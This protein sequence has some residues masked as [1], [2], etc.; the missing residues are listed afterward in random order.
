MENAKYFMEERYGKPETHSAD[1][2]QREHG[3]LHPADS[4]SIG[5]FNPAV[6]EDI[7][8]E[9]RQLE[10]YPRELD[11]LKNSSDGSRE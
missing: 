2:A 7:L 8:R 6:D 1:S 5:D 3:D 9:M 11:N 4:A 10:R